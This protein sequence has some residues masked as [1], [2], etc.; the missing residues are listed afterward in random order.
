MKLSYRWGTPGSS[1][2]GSKYVRAYCPTCGEPMRI[3]RETFRLGLILPCSNCDGHERP[4]G[5]EPPADDYGGMQ[6]NAIRQ[7]EGT[8]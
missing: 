3:S 5:Y 4:G 1:I 7:L 6:A 2:P 8:Y